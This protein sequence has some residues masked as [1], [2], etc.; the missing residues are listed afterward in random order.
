MTIE[1]G[2]LE[3]VPLVFQQTSSLQLDAS[4]PNL[5]FRNSQSQRPTWQ[6]LYR[7]GFS[8]R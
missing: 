1:L 8:A 6:P 4:W 2:K 7:T 3:F 5:L